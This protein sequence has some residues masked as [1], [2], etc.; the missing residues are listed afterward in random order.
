[1]QAATSR[2]NTAPPDSPSH[3]PWWPVAPRDEGKTK[4]IMTDVVVTNPSE[5]REL[6]ID[7]LDEAGGGLFPPGPSLAGAGLFQVAGI[8]VHD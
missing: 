5:M 8:I 4:I 3:R 2:S 1:M 6:T 7:E